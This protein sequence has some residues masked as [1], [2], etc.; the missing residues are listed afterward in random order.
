M[1]SKLLTFGGHLLA[2]KGR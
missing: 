2:N 1:H